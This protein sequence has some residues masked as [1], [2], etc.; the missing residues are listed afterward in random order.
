MAQI[1]RSTKV[2]GLTT[3][4]A[5]TLA[6]AQ[7][8]ED[9]M[10]TLF[11]AHNNHDTGTS[12]WAV[13]KSV[14]ASSVPLSADNSSGT[15][16]IAELKDNGTAVVTVADGGATSLL[17]TG[18][19]AVPLSVNNGTST[20]DIFQANDNGSEVFDI[21]DGG[22]I[23]GTYI[24]KWLSYKRPPLVYVSA[25]QVDI[26]ANTGTANQTRVVFPDGE[27]REV[28]ED[29]SSTHKYRR[30]DITATAEFTSGTEDSGLRNGISE[31]TNTRYMIYLI[32]STID[33]TK[34]VMVGDTTFPTVSNFST[35]NTRYGTNGWIPVGYIFNGDGSGSTGDIVRFVQCGNTTVFRNNCVGNS[36]NGN[37]VRIA[38]TA[39][40]ASLTYTY[41]AGSGSTQIPDTI[42][43][44]YYIG[45]AV[46]DA[47]PR[48]VKFQNASQDIC[49]IALPAS[50]QIQ[51]QF[52]SEATTN[53]NVDPGAGSN[54]AMDIFLYGF[55][56]D[57]LGVGINPLI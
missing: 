10:L 8:V 2:N 46:V 50:A 9:D 55:I 21:K 20:G 37:G 49:S 12:S 28:T 30:F 14:G 45:S 40:A 43:I 19:S 11:N 54:M 22:Q 34:F 27:V 51:Q 4:A 15:Q 48:T 3:L 26:K 42:T 47:N 31:A 23:S 33:L 38:T 29:T 36:A 53:I 32:K 25:T 56:D 16:N 44:A 13:L 35:L 7:D 1:T 57:A 24:S 6:R 39:G 5:H 41:A 18:A 52:I 17:A